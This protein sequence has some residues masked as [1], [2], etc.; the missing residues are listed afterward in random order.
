MET[1]PTTRRITIDDLSMI[2]KKIG[3]YR[4]MI[5]AARAGH[6]SLEAKPGQEEPFLV[7][8]VPPSVHRTIE[9]ALYR[10]AADIQDELLDKYNVEIG[11]G[12]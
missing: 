4:H 2:Q 1:S 3:D 7:S 5:A 9:E 11:K 12:E 6:Y 10:A 8:P